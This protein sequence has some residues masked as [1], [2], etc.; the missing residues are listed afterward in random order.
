MNVDL[1]KFV[2]ELTDRFINEFMKLVFFPF[3]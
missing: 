2:E 1:K 3:Y